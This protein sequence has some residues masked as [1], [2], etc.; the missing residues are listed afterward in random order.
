MT[1]LEKLIKKILEGKTV[2]FNEADLALQNAGFDPE[3]PKSGSSHITYRKSGKNP[4]TL[5]RNRKELK[6]YQLKMIQEALK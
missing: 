6:P 3:S 1:K 4:V 5:V 2:S